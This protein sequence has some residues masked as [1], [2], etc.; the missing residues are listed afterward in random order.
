V[1]DVGRLFYL[2]PTRAPSEVL[3]R[4]RANY[5]PDREIELV[6]HRRWCRASVPERKKGDIKSATNVYREQENNFDNNGF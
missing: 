3:C 5:F 6:T 4:F 1:I 2:T